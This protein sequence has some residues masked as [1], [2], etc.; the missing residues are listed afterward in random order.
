MRYQT[1]T[2]VNSNGTLGETSGAFE[3]T[4][5]SPGTIEFDAMTQFTL[6]LAAVNTGVVVAS[7]FLSVGTVPGKAMF[8]SGLRSSAAAEFATANGLTTLEMTAG[9]SFLDATQSAVLPI[10]RNSLWR[11]ASARFAAGASGDAFMMS[12]YSVRTGGMWMQVE[13]QV[14]MNNSS[15]TGIHFFVP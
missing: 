12:G 13:R 2:S 11:S 3:G 8:W 6:G 5:L 7:R 14:L 15:I 4:Y 1:F 10:F 9:G